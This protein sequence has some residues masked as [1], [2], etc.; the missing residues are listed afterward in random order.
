MAVDGTPQP[1]SNEFQVNTTILNAQTNAAIA[2]LT[3][4][5]FVVA[6]QSD[7]G[8]DTGRLGIFAQ[9]YDASGNKVGAETLIFRL[10]NQSHP[11]VAASTNG[12]FVVTFDASPPPAPTYLGYDIRFAHFNADG[13]RSNG[14]V[15]DYNG[16]G[17]FTSSVVGLP[18]GGFV[19]SWQSEQVDGTFDILAQRYD[20][21]GARAGSAVQVNATV[22][23]GQFA[24]HVAVLAGGGF[25]VAWQSEGQDGNGLGIF[26]R[27]F[28][29]TGAAV[30]GEFQINTHTTNDQINASVA[31]L[32]TGGFVVAWESTGQDGSG[33]GIYGQIYDGSGNRVGGE[34]P[35]NT[36]TS[37]G[38][39][40]PRVAAFP[41]GSFVV[42]WQSAEQDGSGDGVYGQLFSGTGQ[43]IGK[44]FLINDTVG[45]NQVDPVV[46]VA[47]PNDFEVAWTS[48]GDIF[49]RHFF[50]L[51]QEP[52]NHLFTMGADVV[53]FNHIADNQKHAIDANPLS[54]YDGLGGNDVV[55][56]PNGANYQLTATV[57]WDPSDAFVAGDLSG[58][59][60]S[61][62]GGD[63][64]DILIGG[65][66]SDTLDGRGGKDTL[67][68]GIGADKFVYTSGSGPD[69][70][71]DFSGSIGN[72]GVPG[73]GEGDTI[74]LTAVAGIHSLAD[75]QSRATQSGADAVIDFGNGNTLTLNSVDKTDLVAADFVLAPAPEPEQ[76]PPSIAFLAELALAAYHLNREE[77]SK[78]GFDKD[79]GYLADA[80][81]ASLAAPNSTFHFLTATGA[82][83]DLY[84]APNTDST[85]NLNFPIT[86]L[87]D[88]IYVQDNAS[89]LVGQQDRILF[90]AFRGTNDGTAT[91]G[92]IL[93]GLAN[94]STPDIN[95]FSPMEYYYNKLKPLLDDIKQYANDANSGITQIYVTGHSLGASMVQQFMR[96]PAVAGDPRYQAITFADPGFAV[97]IDTGPFT[98][99]ED[100]LLYPVPLSIKEPPTG[101]DTRILNIRIDGDPISG[102][103]EHPGLEALL[104]YVVGESGRF[105]PI[106]HALDVTGDLH[107][108]G[109]Y[110]QT[111]IAL[112][113]LHFPVGLISDF[114]STKAYES[115]F[116][117]IPTDHTHFAAISYAWAPG[118]DGVV[119]SL[120]NIDWNT[121]LAGDVYHLPIKAL[122][123]SS[124][125]D[126]LTGGAGADILRGGPGNDILDGGAGN[127]TAVYDGKLYNLNGLTH[128]WWQNPDGSWTVADQSLTALSSGVDT[129]RNIQQLKFGDTTFDL[130]TTH[131]GFVTKGRI[132]DGTVFADAD[133]NGYLD[134]GE[135][136]TRTNADGSY[137]L[138]GGSGPLI[139][140]GG[141]DT[142]TGLAFKGQLS[143]PSGSSVVTPLTTLLALL[144]T[145]AIA[146]QKVLS[147]FGLSSSIDLNTFDPIAAAQA[148]STDSVATTAAVAKVYDTVSL[149]ASTL[150]AA[151]GDFSSGVKEAFA[152]I[153]AAIGGSGISLTNEAQVSALIVVT[154]QSKGLTLG[155]GV[156]DSVAAIITASNILLDQQA[157]SGATGEELLNAI[158]AIERVIQ[159]TASNAIQQAGNDADQLQALVTAFSGDKLDDAV[160]TALSHLGVADTT[161]PT[162]TPVADQ[163]N[164]A[165]SAAGATA[166][167][168]AT[169]SDNVDG[170][171]PVVFKEG[172]TVVHS[173][174]VFGLGSHT[175]TASAIDAAGNQTFENFKFNVVDTTA[176]TLTPVPDQTLEAA[177]AAG[178]AAFFIATATDAVDGADIVVF[179][180]GNNVIQSG[181]IFGLGNHT[182]TASTIDAA[183]NLSSETFT[184]NVKDTTAPTLT[185]I[186]DQTLQATTSAGATA[187]FAA[188]AT[189]LVDGTDP[190][191]FKEGNTV[192]HSGDIFGLGIHAITANTVDVTGNASSESFKIEVVGITSHN[193]DPIAVADSNDVAKGTT[194][195]VSTSKGVLANDS[196]SD[197]DHLTVGA[198]N[199]SA[200]NVGHSV[201][202]DY[203]TLTLNADGS[204]SYAATAEALPSQ[205]FAQDTFNYTN[206]DGH[207][208]SD[209]ST[210]T[211]AVFAP[212]FS[213]QAGSNNILWG[214]NGKNVLDGSAGH[215]LL[216]G[217]NGPDV[218]IGGKGDIL[219]GGKGPDQFVFRPDFGAN[220]ILD[221]D[222]TNDRLQFDNSVFESVRSILDHTT[223]TAV[224]A[225]ISD[226]H[227]DSILLLG[228]SKSQ[229]VAH[230]SDLL[231]A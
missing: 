75:V 28:D 37:N 144:A 74:D 102:S 230:S 207:G 89:A 22:A 168:I 135:S 110:Y 208:G 118:P 117:V 214:G 127:N 227:E 49:A 157:Q 122:V 224:G 43:K 175:I 138:L 39:G 96:D 18:D 164:E 223:N 130:A 169:A 88:G 161:A 60:A 151:G 180:D 23:D 94:E 171:I 146:E 81:Y 44:E 25:V 95:D 155:Q 7:L 87:L 231:I 220:T 203:G 70:I 202:G 42:V 48:G 184:I 26:G 132:S 183:G 34:F 160:S 3:D 210:L 136:F 129:L 226:G 19:V 116:K 14:V 104:G 73:H 159:G 211:F 64:A 179:K 152:A 162:L 166:F 2:G 69:T 212:S 16:L 124:F 206:V 172:S 4:G 50:M 174:D 10:I 45:G 66:G 71:T 114:S 165:T 185:S 13:T 55:I 90:V 123:G 204:Y 133:G 92:E 197:H 150:V 107:D 58:Q 24:P 6:W 229:L 46:T 199:G 5:G 205:I 103:M 65:Q 77:I 225:L 35:I 113:N 196:D 15:T 106:N 190:V 83:S 40:S 29:Q 221:F 86:G 111:A 115:E 163:T 76:Q 119:A 137:V 177:K 126:D 36:Y 47:G 109:L 173:G 72:D 54:I 112:D 38:Q 108:M 198:V 167:F 51:D 216:Y 32:S 147:S 142:S 93:K 99:P 84:P 80:L 182:I 121:L 200:T 20:A 79:G 61:I 158:A 195:S 8:D 139:A 215:D 187:F 85:Y 228:L 156:A 56:L 134:P 209:T 17:D 153:A 12:G 105:L 30:G 181:D 98:R 91:P 57:R 131:V 191:V 52:S 31:G 140:F 59:T 148:G 100:E 170:T 154:A 222:V 41:D 186:A 149:I 27:R 11:S 62:T 143:A 192:V 97:P 53:D 178:A 213:Y 189:D 82:F 1:A 68:G 217:G 101:A 128:R 63:G 78:D 120:G 201:K 125:D 67:T 141:T 21:S 219:A 176:P 188:T 194:I 193:H 9:R 33:G 218:L 145:D